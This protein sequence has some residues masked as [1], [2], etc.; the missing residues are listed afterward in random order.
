M[1]DIQLLVESEKYAPLTESEATSMSMLLKNTQNEHDRL[2]TEGTIS[3]DIATFTPILMPM[4]RRVY[5]NLIAQHILGVQP[6]STPTGF[7]YALVNQYIGTGDQNKTTYPGTAPTGPGTTGL[8]F[9]GAKSGDLVGKLRIVKQLTSTA[10][11]STLVASPFYSEVQGDYTLTL[12]LKRTSGTALPAEHEEFSNESAF[13]V[14]L[15]D[16]TGTYTTAQAEMLGK[17]MREVGF[18]IVKKSIEAKSHALKGRYTVEMYEDLKNQHGL[19][20]DDE[21]MSLMSHEIQMEIDRKCVNFVNKHATHTPDTKFA[22]RTNMDRNDGRWELERFRTYATRI[23]KEATQIGLDTKRGQGNI[24][25]VSPK[26]AT[27][28]RQL[29]N[30]A[31]APVANTFSNGVLG[32]YIGTF[33]G[34]FK[35]VVDQWA[36]SDYCTVLYKG[37]DRRDAM[38]FFCPY[39]PLSFMRVVDPESGQPAIIAKTRY[40]LETIPGVKSATSNDRAQA[41]ARSFAVD[42]AGTVLA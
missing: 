41:Y 12:A 7:I 32:G 26:V 9:A 1:N 34:Q 23:A 18:Q 11:G 35:V 22:D 27:M 8:G 21:I 36:V 37:V 33:D 29:G 6:M 40:G 10:K 39:V 17:D 28:L 2:M 4:V 15:K 24:L 14:I 16:Y 5:P 19:L 31:T 20:A 3:A 38:G 25:L 13:S 42:F 30:F